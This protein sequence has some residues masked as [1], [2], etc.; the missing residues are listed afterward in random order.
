M[1][2]LSNYKDADST[3][4]A[5]INQFYVL[6]NAGDYDAAYE[7]I[8]ANKKNLAPYFINKDSFNKIELGIYELAKHQFYANKIIISDT[9]PSAAEINIGSEWLEEY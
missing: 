5:I 3:V 4:S 1:F 8:E 6:R 9:E 2:E 7:L